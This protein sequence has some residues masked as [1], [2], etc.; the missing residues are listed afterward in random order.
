LPIAELQFFAFHFAQI[1]DLLP[2]GF[3]HGVISSKGLSWA[4]CP[5]TSEFMNA[6]QGDQKQLSHSGVSS[7]VPDVDI[8]IFFA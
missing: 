8:R 4:A 6:L 1:F 3:V 2:E 7:A 5:F